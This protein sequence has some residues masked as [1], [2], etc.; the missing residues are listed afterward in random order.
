MMEMYLNAG[1]IQGLSVD[2]GHGWNQYLLL[3]NCRDKSFPGFMAWNMVNNFVDINNRSTNLTSPEFISFLENLMAIYQAPEAIVLGMEMA[4]NFRFNTSVYQRY[5]QWGPLPGDR[6]PTPIVYVDSTSFQHRFLGY[7]ALPI[8]MTWGAYIYAFA[9]HNEFLSPINAILPYYGQ[10]PFVG[11]IPLADQYGRL[12]TNMAATFPWKTL[13]IVDNENALLAWDFVSQYLLQASVCLDATS[14][15]IPAS[16]D[17][18]VQPNIGVASFDTPIARGLAHSL[19][20]DVLD[21]TQRITWVEHFED[22]A[23]AEVAFDL[24]MPGM[25]G[26]FTQH[27]GLPIE[28][29]LDA[30]PATTTQTIQHTIQQIDTLHGRPL[31]TIP[32]IPFYMIESTILNMLRRNISPEDAAAALDLAIGVWLG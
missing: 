28:G 16:G 2:A 26:G 22:A 6:H 25:T 24:N 13:S 32:F 19:I 5:S 27:V 15:L 17:L 14:V 3:A 7:M 23:D 9:V 30:D 31:A 8:D 1:P 18:I 29:L 10:Q 4:H 21:R 20:E 12:V 11:F